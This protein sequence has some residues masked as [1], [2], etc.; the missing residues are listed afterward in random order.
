MEGLCR[1]LIQSARLSR[2]AV[3][4]EYCVR[5]KMYRE[6]ILRGKSELC[7]DF[8]IPEGIDLVDS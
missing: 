5:R 4:L 1:V 3:V 6:A 8:G 7:L 2:S